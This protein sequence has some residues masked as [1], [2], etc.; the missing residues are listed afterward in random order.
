MTALP[1]L[2]REPALRDREGIPRRTFLQ[3]VS[4]A[5]ASVGLTGS[6]AMRVVERPREGSSPP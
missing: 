6:A 3:V 4:M 1:F 2:P 5:A